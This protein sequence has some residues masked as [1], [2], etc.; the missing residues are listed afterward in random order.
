MIGKSPKLLGIVE[1]VV[2]ADVKLQSFAVQ[3]DEKSEF[4]YMF[5]STGQLIGLFSIL[6]DDP[7]FLI[8]FTDESS[9]SLLILHL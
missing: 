7:N 1:F 3:P 2:L 5:V 4:L 8:N 6:F 9:K